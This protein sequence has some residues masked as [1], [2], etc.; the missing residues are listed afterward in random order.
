[1]LKDKSVSKCSQVEVQNISLLLGRQVKYQQ[2][3]PHITKLYAEG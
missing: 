1:M 3:I 2:K